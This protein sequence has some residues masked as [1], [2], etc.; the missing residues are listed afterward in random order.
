MSSSSQAPQPAKAKKAIGHH[1]HNKGYGGVNPAS[2]KQL[3]YSA[4][5]SFDSCAEQ[6]HKDK[7]PDNQLLKPEAKDS[8]AHYDSYES[9]VP[10][11]CSDCSWVLKAQQIQQRG[12]KRWM[13]G[14]LFNWWF[15]RSSILEVN[16]RQTW[17]LSLKWIQACYT[18][19][20]SNPWI[21]ILNQK[22]ILNQEQLSN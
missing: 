15:D 10:P 3:V 13:D 14:L 22:K 7:S 17:L 20:K 4:T 2:V 9:Q 16:N 12:I 1:Q 21:K 18:Y 5:F 8:W 11:P 19:S 6:S